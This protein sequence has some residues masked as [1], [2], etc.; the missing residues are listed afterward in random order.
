MFKKI[1][2]ATDGSALAD[3]AVHA[4]I[5]LASGLNARVVVARVVPHY[6]TAYFE[7]AVAMLPQ[8][9][10]RIEAQW[11]GEA[12]K[13]V[14]QACTTALKHAV[15]ATPVTVKSDLIA[16]ALVN[17]AKKHKCDLIVMASHGYKAFK[18]LLLGSETL[19]VLTH[20]HIPVLVLR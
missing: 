4:G 8:D 12:E 11:Q 3:K 5:T 19:H 16:E 10:A 13:S 18:R 17:T 7:G 2:I 20:S 6:P 14:E 9:I 1:L 15:K